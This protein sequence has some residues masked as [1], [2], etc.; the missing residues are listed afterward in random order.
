MEGVE[1]THFNVP[2]GI[3]VYTYVIGKQTSENVFNQLMSSGNYKAKRY[4]VN[5]AD[6]NVR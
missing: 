1:S 3:L 6:L 5:A 4:I 2:D